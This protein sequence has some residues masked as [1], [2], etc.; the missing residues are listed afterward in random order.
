M[1]LDLPTDLHPLRQ[2]L[3]QCLRIRSD[4]QAPALPEDLVRDLGPATTRAVR[5]TSSPGWLERLFSTLRSPAFGAVAVVLLVLSLAAPKLREFSGESFRGGEAAA[6][7][8]PRLIVI[9]G[10]AGERA[11]LQADEALQPLETRHFD[12]SAELPA[13]SGPCLVVDLAASRVRILDGA[14]RELDALVLPDDPAQRGEL[15][16]SA[17]QRL[18]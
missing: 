9:G 1:D 18:D 14:G 13:L 11:A 5:G 2:L 6:L 8:A 3:G 4:E 16:A 15:I 10:S 12:S 7:P 17:L